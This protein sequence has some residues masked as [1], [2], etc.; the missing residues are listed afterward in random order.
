MNKILL[1]DDDIEIT[2][3]LKELL[4]L[5]GFTTIVTHDGEEALEHFD[6]S[7]DLVLLDV[8]MPKMNGIDTLKRLRRDFTVPVIMLTAK[9]SELDRVLGLELGADDYIPK[10][11]NDRELIARI[12]AL[13]RRSDWEDKKEVVD[14]STKTKLSLDKLTIYP[15][16]QE[17]FFDGQRINFT[18]TE[19]CLLQLLLENAGE[20]VSRE[21]LSMKVLGKE[22]S[23][24]DRAI[25]MHISNLRKKLP[26]RHDGR[27][28]FKTL[29]AKGYLMVAQGS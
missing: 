2:S 11:F 21:E 17:A 14:N 8:M 13:L 9:G 1:V 7:I 3:L 26:S 12:R 6:E 22:L 5:E 23:P 18:G 19:F 28:W 4:E 10:P 24:F 20:V 15:N 27:P 16:H 25:D 29:R